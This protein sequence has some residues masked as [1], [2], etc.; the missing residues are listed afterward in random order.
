MPFPI[1]YTKYVLVYFLVETAFKVVSFTVVPISQFNVVR[2]VQPK[3]TPSGIVEL[4][5]TPV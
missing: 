5:P 1:A 2:E 3:K 4:P